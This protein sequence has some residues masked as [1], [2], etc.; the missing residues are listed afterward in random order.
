L[1]DKVASAQKT[2]V[3]S[4]IFTLFFCILVSRAG[5]AETDSIQLNADKVSYE[6]STGVAVAEGNV[7]INNEDFRVFAPYLEY[8]SN[9]QQVTALSS[10]SGGVTFISDGKRLSGERLDYNI[11]TRKG[12]LTLPN[13]KIDSFYVKGSAIRVMPA[14]ELGGK[15][16]SAGDSE[17]MSAV[18][19]EASLTTCSDP[20]PH[21]RLEAKEVTVIPGRKA[22]I[23]RPKVY[24]GDTM[25]FIYP[26][27]YTIKFGS[28]QRGRNHTIFPK[29]G[30][31]SDKGAGIGLSGSIGWDSGEIDIEAI[32]WSKGIWEGEALLTQEIGA[33]LSI[34]GA[35]KREY[36]KDLRVTEWRP[37]W[38]LD[39]EYNE[40]KL[41]V[42]W[43]ERELVNIEKRAG[44]DSRYV[45]WRKPEINILSPWFEDVA[46]EGRY[47]FFATWGRYE[48]VSSLIGRQQITRTGA[49][50]QVY[51]DFDGTS[52]RFRPF[53]NLVYLYYSYDDPIF[54]N[55]QI[56]DSAVGMRWKIGE[57]DLET[58]YLRRWT[59]GDSPMLWDDYD[60]R[61]EIYQEL[62]Y[63]I[64]T[65]SKDLSWKLGLRAAY[66]VKERE[67]AELVYKVSYDQHCLLWEATFRD[68]RVGG[69]DWFGL[70]LTIKEYPKSGVRLTGAELF[71]PAEAPG[72][73]VPSYNER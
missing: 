34:Y 50:V 57:I 16:N 27:D 13:G 44:V 9:S 29:L 19:S 42:G 46:V 51:R 60:E 68:D 21:Y 59:W 8:D 40:W 37:R 66:D 38:G 54:E 45:V 69:D 5:A 58:A 35:V 26:F 11:E 39:Y 31:E 53:Y 33:G 20:H 17:E 70:T 6:E 14:E 36:D 43:S 47:R 32:G 10:Q 63:T 65:K 67:L 4:L 62:N 22:I 72:E 12:I 23:R 3:L 28:N 1:E 2:V 64:P 55:Q 15:K 24:L 73:L 41:R 7:R 71:D 56:L 49:G 18:W 52:E 25:I 48:D 61:E 30:Y